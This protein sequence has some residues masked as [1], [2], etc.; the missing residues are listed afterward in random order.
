MSVVPDDAIARELIGTDLRATFGPITILR[1]K[2]QG[3]CASGPAGAEPSRDAVV[4]GPSS[5]SAENAPL[6]RG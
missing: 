5:R 2:F 3:A 1:E 4:G 6:R